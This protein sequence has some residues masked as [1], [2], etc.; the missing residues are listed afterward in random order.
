MTAP[1]ANQPREPFLLCLLF[2]SLV[3]LILQPDA[4]RRFHRTES[5]VAESSEN[6]EG[7]G[8]SSVERA[9]QTRVCELTR[10]ANSG[11]FFHLEWKTIRPL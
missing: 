11:G 8:R 3:F 10:Q 6:S 7:M 9:L 2:R 4:A 5:I 1:G